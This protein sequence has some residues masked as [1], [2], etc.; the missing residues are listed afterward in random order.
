MGKLKQK[1]DK[2]EKKNE[3]TSNFRKQW[4]KTKEASV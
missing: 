3:K 4:N 2:Q 1:K